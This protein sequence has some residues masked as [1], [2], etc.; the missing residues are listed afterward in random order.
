MAYITVDPVDDVFGREIR[1][2]RICFNQ[3][4][5]ECFNKI[6]PLFLS[7][8]VYRFWTTCEMREM[9]YIGLAHPEV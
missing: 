4:V 2:L 6:L 1:Y 5:R 3:Y 8:T 9:P 7:Q